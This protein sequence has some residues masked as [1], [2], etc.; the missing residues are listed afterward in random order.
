MTRVHS[1]DHIALAERYVVNVILPNLVHVPN[2][3]VTKGV[4]QD[5]DLIIGMDIITLGDFA[6]TNFGGV[7]KFSFRVP[8]LRHIDFVEEAANR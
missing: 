5:S 4:F 3:E 7:T 2:L 8:S 6:V 1:V